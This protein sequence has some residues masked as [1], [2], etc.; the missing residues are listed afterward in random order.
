MQQVLCTENI[1]EHNDLFKNDK[2]FTDGTSP[3]I[4]KQGQYSK[5]V[6]THPTHSIDWICMWKKTNDL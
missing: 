1:N 6:H 3:K 2:E 4:K 5:D